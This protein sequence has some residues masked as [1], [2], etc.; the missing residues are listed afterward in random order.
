MP[1][2]LLPKW[3]PT[4]NL[5]KST[6]TQSCFGPGMGAPVLTNTSGAFLKSWGIVAL[7]FETEEGAWSQHRPKDADLMM[8]EQAA[9]MKKMAPETQVWVYRNLIQPYANF[10][11]LREKIEDPQYS[12]W[13]MHFDNAGSGSGL[14]CTPTTRS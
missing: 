8:V 2:L 7:D 6:M 11:Q 9:V 3:Q 14:L 12:G 13:F 4:Y 5:T 10:V 1:N